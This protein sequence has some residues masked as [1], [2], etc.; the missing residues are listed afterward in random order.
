MACSTLTYPIQYKPN[1]A[2][3][4]SCHALYAQPLK[5]SDMPH[6]FARYVQESEVVGK[7]ICSFTFFKCPSYS[8]D[9]PHSIPFFPVETM[10]KVCLLVQEA[11]GFEMDVCRNEE[12]PEVISALHSSKTQTKALLLTDSGNHHYGA[13]VYH[14]TSDGS[15]LLFSFDSAHELCAEDLGITDDTFTQHFVFNNDEPQKDLS[16]CSLYAL[17]FAT[18]AMHKI[19]KLPED[20]LLRVAESMKTDD[21]EA[22]VHYPRSWLPGNQTIDTEADLSVMTFDL[23]QG[24][25]VSL[26]AFY[27]RHKTEMAIEYSIE[28][29][30][31]DASGSVEKIEKKG[32]YVQVWN[33]YLY[34]MGMAIVSMLEEEC[35]GK[36]AA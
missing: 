27:E 8:E 34:S 36:E 1:G 19:G 22:I 15:P 32:K 30:L 29:G 20:E 33:T 2:G 10:K 12:L 6:T 23:T 9:Y 35:K 4:S 18:S 21:E 11:F 7:K 28:A 14:R 17:H 25:E 26:E 16:T 13:L 31:V 5:Y 24:K 3:L